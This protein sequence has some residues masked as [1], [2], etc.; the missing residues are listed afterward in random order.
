M[1]GSLSLLV[2]FV[3]YSAG[4]DAQSIDVVKPDAELPYE[5]VMSENEDVSYHHEVS[6]L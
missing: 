1:I 5:L 4:V 6:T 3:S 2:L